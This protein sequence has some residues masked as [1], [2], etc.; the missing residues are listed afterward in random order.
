MALH[1]FATE[2]KA[3]LSR[4]DTFLFFHTLLNPAYLVL[5]LDINGDL[6]N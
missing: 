6:P 2:Y 3:L 4:W 5:G 1:L